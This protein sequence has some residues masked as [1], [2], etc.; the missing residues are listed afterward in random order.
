MDRRFRAIAILV[1]LAAIAVVV[2][3][4]RHHRYRSNLPGIPISVL[5]ADRPIPKG[6]PGRVMR[7]TGGYYKLANIP[8]A[9]ILAGAIF[10]PAVL[11]GKVALL[12]IPK[13]AQLLAADFGSAK[14]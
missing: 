3:S 10:D 13:G 6:T 4:H 9:Q 12:D 5:V 7:T 11:A 8:K 14:R 1:A 2:I